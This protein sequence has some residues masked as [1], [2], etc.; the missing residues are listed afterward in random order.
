MELTIEQYVQQMF[1][2]RSGVNEDRIS[3]IDMIH[4]D[5]VERIT[6]GFPLYHIDAYNVNSCIVPLNNKQDYYH[7][8]DHSMFEYFE[9]FLYCFEYNLPNLAIAIYKQLRSDICISQGDKTKA[10]LYKGSPIYVT[11]YDME[12]ENLYN[13]D[14]FMK[15]Y[16]IM[17][18]FYFFHE[19]AHYMISNPLQEHSA[20]EA[21]DIIIDL[22][23][24]SM[25]GAINGKPVF[26]RIIQNGLLRKYKNE[27]FKNP[28]F[29]EEIMCDFQ[30]LLCLLELVEVYSVETIIE[31]IITFIYTQYYIWLTKKRDE[32]IGFG[33]IF[34]FRL[35]I[36]FNFAYFLE[37]KAFS[38]MIC[39]LLNSSNKYN[40]IR[41]LQSSIINLQKYNDFYNKYI[42]IYL[43]DSKHDIIF[44]D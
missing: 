2:L 3:D 37:D 32:K 27:Y 9:R 23:F 24:K 34:H 42:R 44:T 22:V 25:R 14:D 31:A 36:F 41:D 28:N 18:M 15:K 21:L 17:V 40:N 29:H 19:Y 16:R 13:P 7:V 39:N 10:E 5:V 30:A 43:A 33:N 4:S 12:K 8:I 26:D 6:F 20:D 11:N 35:N 38:D 1:T